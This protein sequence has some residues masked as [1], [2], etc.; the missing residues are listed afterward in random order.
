[1]KPIKTDSNL[2]IRFLS[3][4]EE[5]CL[6]HAL[7]RREER[8]RVDRTNGNLWRESRGKRLML[9]LNECYFADHLKPM[10]LLSINTGIR[11]GELFSLSWKNVDFDLK[12]ITIEGTNAKSRKLR[13]VPLNSEAL[14]TL[15]NWKA[16]AT[17]NTEYVFINQFGR[18]FADIKTAWKR[19]LQ[20]ADIH[21]FRWHDLRHHFASRLAMAGVDLN[22]IRE[23]L[24]HSSYSM[25]LRYAHLSQGHKAKAVSHLNTSV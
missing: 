24:G 2:K 8:L 5:T 15:I 7:D 23:L 16:Q 14:Q 4:S 20:D 12:Q 18:R 25:T 3:K 13:Y 11:K 1:M 21:D 6:R 10:V 17:C 19:L 22:T 9:D